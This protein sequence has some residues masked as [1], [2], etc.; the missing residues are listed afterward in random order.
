MFRR[1]WQCWTVS[2]CW[3]SQRSCAAQTTLFG[4]RHFAGSLRLIFYWGIE[5]KL[6]WLRSCDRD[7][8]IKHASSNVGRI[9]R[10]TRSKRISP[11]GGLSEFLELCSE[12]AERLSNLPQVATFMFIWFALG[13]F[14]TCCLKILRWR[15]NLG[16]RDIIG[17]KNL[18]SANSRP[19]GSNCKAMPCRTSSINSSRRK[20][21]TAQRDRQSFQ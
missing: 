8:E 6:Q 18:I 3:H 20:N 12:G 17:F 13:K 16:F 11:D 15:C 9:T 5:Y 21:F 10:S 1:T 4:I 14:F 2:R 19:C 7:E